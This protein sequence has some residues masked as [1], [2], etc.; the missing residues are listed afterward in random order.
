MN[1]SGSRLGA[2]SCLLHKVYPPRS[3][4]LLQSRIS[5]EHTIETMGSYTSGLTET[6][7]AVDGVMLDRYLVVECGSI[8]GQ[9][10]MLHRRQICVLL[11]V[12]PWDMQP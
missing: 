8:E 1:A 5:K 11:S 10:L 4:I 6:T 2:G 7:W 3:S 9:A 12:P